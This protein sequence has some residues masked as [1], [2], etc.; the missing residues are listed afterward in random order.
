MKIP[1]GQAG[2]KCR[3]PRC[4]AEVLAPA[5][6][7]QD[8]VPINTP[9]AGHVPSGSASV[10]GAK[11]A[12][13]TVPVPAVP[14]REDAAPDDDEEF[15]LGE[16]VERLP[17]AYGLPASLH[18]RATANP[19]AETSALAAPRTT[20][21]RANVGGDHAGRVAAT[22][23]AEEIQRAGARL[24]ERP[25][26]TCLV[27]FLSDRA[28][29]LRWF[30]LTFLLYAAV[31]L[32]GWIVDLSRG[33]GTA[34]MGAL[35]ITLGAVVVTVVLVATAAAI[36][37]AILQDTASGRDKV[38]SWPGM[39]FTDWVM[40]VFY[41][42]NALLTAALPGLFVGG[43]LMCLGG[44][45]GSAIYGGALSA[46]VLFPLFLISMVTEGSAF[47]VASPAVWGTVRTQPRLWGKF[48]L[49]SG[50]LS[51]VLL[52]L[53]RMMLGSGFF[54]QGLC[55][56][57]AVAASMIYFRLLGTLAWCLSEK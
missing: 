57:G 50:A 5:V 7:A 44:K 14:L 56:A 43:A 26:V 23:T 3:C 15:R 48:Y 38:E 30:M 4:N 19:P 21:G 10:V 34:Q 40:D 53:G 51:L 20:G 2:Q 9:H 32:F 52:M 31:V 49:L 25:F 27:S 8:A 33:S 17:A 22:A 18:D 54:L 46:I 13:H 28:A 39:P 42:V 11:P 45:V 47:S 1:P 37:L 6:P 12:P 24:P 29:Q 36:G 41:V 16:V 35:I 55:S